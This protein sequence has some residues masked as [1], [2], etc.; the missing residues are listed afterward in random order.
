[1]REI[2]DPDYGALG[3]RVAQLRQELDW[4]LDELADESGLDRKTVINLENSH[5]I[6]RLATVH[7]LAHALGVPLGELVGALC[8][9]HGD[10]R[11]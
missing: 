3:H 6:P 7:A 5:H 2:P 1:M 8:S 4:S 9:G 11:Q 10:G